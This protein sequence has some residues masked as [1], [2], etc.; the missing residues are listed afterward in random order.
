MQDHR[1]QARGGG[2]EKQGSVCF[3]IF[4]SVLW[5]KIHLK[6][7][8]E[9]VSLLTQNFRSVA[10]KAAEAEDRVG[11]LSKRLK[12]VEAALERLVMSLQ[13]NPQK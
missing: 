7:L 8:L 6:S 3:V 10:E 5:Y 12:G 9:I 4:P 2:E 11:E 1:H 13:Q